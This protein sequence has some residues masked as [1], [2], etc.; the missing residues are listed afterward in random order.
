M[1]M[2]TFDYAKSAANADALASA[3]TDVQSQRAQ[4]AQY[5]I[6]KAAGYLQNS[7]NDEAMKEF[8]KALAFD[9]QNSTAHTYIGKIYQS[10]GKNAEAIN[11]FKSVVQNDRTSVTA[12]VNL[13]NAYM[14]DKQ[15]TAA[16]KE[17]KAA[18]KMDP[19]NPLAD[20]TLGIMYTQ[21]DRFSEA[22]AQF[23]K[24]AKVS[25]RDGNVFYALGALYNKMGRPE[26][27]VKQLEK[28][29]TLKKD[30]ANA[31]FELG[32]AY[33]TLGNT[34]KA[35]EQK[36]ILLSKDTNLYYSLESILNTPKMS[37]I[38]SVKNKSFNQLLGPSTPLWMLDPT[39]MEANASKKVTVAIAFNNKMDIA[40]VMNPANW[41]ISRAK[42][43][44]GG[45]YNNSMPATSREATIP[46][47][48]FLVTYDPTTG[49]ASV[50]FT[51]QQNANGD[52]TIDPSHLVFKF[53]GKDADGRAMDTTGDQIDG[54]AT[55]PF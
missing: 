54:Y 32:S 13:G 41:E 21:T 36:S 29:L 12:R 9:P 27:A 22:E 16:E 6:Q 39:L 31:N 4:L 5:A 23:N 37:Y 17:F 44:E 11:E 28:S 34:D 30:F 43:A 47:R 51:L 53:S 35:E 42:S 14:Q 33:A 1:I 3:N 24:V 7:Q 10:Q 20:Y 50:T 46:R 15:Y 52:A 45:Y 19:L 26:D 55:K 49:Q 38:D 48:P 18:A 8:K 2:A 40:S 25:P